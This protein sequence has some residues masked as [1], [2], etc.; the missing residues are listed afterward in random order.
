M[1]TTHAMTALEK[2]A[3]DLRADLAHLDMLRRRTLEGL[4]HIEAT[5]ALLQAAKKGGAPNGFQRRWLFRR[6]ELKRLILEIECEAGER[7]TARATARVI[8]A[9]RG[10]DASDRR[11]ENLLAMKVRNAWR[12]MPPCAASSLSKSG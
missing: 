3:A 10:W 8:I 11:L 12:L 4:A 2:K 6:G 5:L 7:P 1:A 9:R